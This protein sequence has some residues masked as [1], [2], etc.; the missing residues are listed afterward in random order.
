MR[1]I[2]NTKYL[3]H[4]LPNADRLFPK[5][6]LDVSVTFCT[7]AP[8]QNNAGMWLHANCTEFIKLEDWLPYLPDLNPL[9]YCI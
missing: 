1:N 9:D 4:I 2:K 6:E 3:L 5:K 8:I 7:V